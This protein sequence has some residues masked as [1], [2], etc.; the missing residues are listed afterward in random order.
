[1]AT[2]PCTKTVRKRGVVTKA[3]T[4]LLTQSCRCVVCRVYHTRGYAE[5]AV[6][7][8]RHAPPRSQ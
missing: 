6:N 4:A 3:E 7:T 8:A 1:M 2:R 5:R